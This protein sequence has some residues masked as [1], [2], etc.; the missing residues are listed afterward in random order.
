M[1]WRKTGL[2]AIPFALL[3]G[4][5]AVN[6]QQ[7]AATD[8]TAEMIAGTLKQAKPAAPISDLPIRVVDAGGHNVGI[9]IVRRTVAESQSALVHHKITEV[10]LIQDGAGILVTG[11]TLVNSVERPASD[12]IGPSASGTDIKDGTRRHVKPGDVIIIPARV[13]H[14]F[15]ELE[16]PITYLMLRVDPDQVLPLK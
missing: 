2:A 12:V 7:I 10:Y 16:G 15:I 5:A 8:V 9:A 13:P 1:L 3:F 14:R 6:G 11:G 4:A